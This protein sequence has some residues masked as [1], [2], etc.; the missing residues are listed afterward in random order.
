[1]RK[2]DFL[3]N[4]PAELIAQVPARPR[5]AARLMCLGRAGGEIQ[6]RHFRELPELLRPGDLLVVNDS[7]VLPARL[8]G[9]RKGHEGSCEL[10][11][12]R[13][14]EQDVWECLAKPGC[15][16]RP[17]DA[18]VFGD[19]SLTAQVL[20]TLENGS[21][22][23]RFLYDTNTLQ[24]KLDIFGE[25]PLPP[26]IT[27]RASSKEDYQTVYARRPGS[28]AAPTAGLHFTPELLRALQNAGV[29]LARLTLHVGLG[30]FR[31]MQE[32]EIERHRMHSE[33]FSLNDEAAKAICLAKKEGRRVIAVG[34]TS[35][36]ALE[37]V[38][39][40]YGEICPASGE[41]DIFIHPG[42]DFRVVDGL[43]TNFHL[44]ESTL[45]MLV[46]AFAGYENTMRAY[47]EAVD[48]KYRF[49]S[50]GDAM[51]LL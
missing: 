29:G 3:Y 45:I 11:L 50:F 25:M 27:S 13:Q 1:M 10:L 7:K 40:S 32:E 48:Q 34:T 9:C 4:L 26:Y 24:E 30:T 2:S 37:S 19:G 18:L 46:A 31:P 41:T 8:I 43:I 23:V 22:K 17:G 33:W 38:A 39:E 44:P 6:H 42:H 15:R 28:A 36:R 20:A 49:F 47:Q 21:K 5:D 35:C 12:L 16:I 14:D 51:L